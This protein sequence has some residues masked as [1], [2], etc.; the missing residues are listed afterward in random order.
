MNHDM[1]DRLAH[2]DE[3]AGSVPDLSLVELR[4]RQIRGRRVARRTLAAGGLACA[5]TFGLAALPAVE[6]SP[7]GTALSAYLGVAAASSDDGTRDCRVSWASGLLD[8]AGW[9]QDPAITSAVSVVGDL[10]EDI[11]S[12]AAYEEVGQCPPLRPV[13]VLVDDAPVRGITVWSD[14]R[15]AYSGTEGAVDVTV[16][17]VAGKVFEMPGG[18]VV[19]W[20]VD[21]VHWYSEGSGLTDTDLVAALDALTFGAEGDVDPTSAPAGFEAVALPPRTQD[22]RVVRWE[23][24]YDDGV[25]L[26]VTSAPVHPAEVNMSRSVE[27]IDLVDVDG[28]RGVVTYLGPPSDPQVGVLSWSANGVSCT[29]NGPVDA[30]LLAELAESV[31]AVPL[32]APELAGVLTV[33]AVE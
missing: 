4:A 27:G 25:S 33:P 8:P 21:G 30:N 20:Q 16:R 14:V 17:G 19:T 1:L 24:T 13:A 5:L 15:D 7:G 3:A 9:A 11:T 23:T 32:T 12:A 22:T 28:A 26:I 31:V 18:W 10:S 6:S 2:V 29:I